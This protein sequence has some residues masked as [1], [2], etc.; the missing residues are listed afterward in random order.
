MKKIVVCIIIIFFAIFG[1]SCG[2][3]SFTG[4]SIPPEAET[5][6]ISYFPNQAQIINPTLSQRFTEELQDKFTRQTNLN[7]IES[8]G[9]LHFEGVITE[10]STRPISIQA[11]DRP[12]QNRLTIS[13]RVSFDNQYDPDSNFERAF[14]RYYEYPSNRSLTEVEQEAIS[15]ISEALVDD[16]FNQSVVNW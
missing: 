12:A 11:D 3:Y 4:A 15:Y 8:N 5:V 1:N 2:F 13:V 10:Y 9:D 7:L 14:S 16:I 6:S